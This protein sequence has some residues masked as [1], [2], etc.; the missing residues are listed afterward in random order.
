MRIVIDFSRTSGAIRSC[1]VARLALLLCAF[2]GFSLAAR[3]A[4]TTSGEQPT[5]AVRLHSSFAFADF[6][7]DRQPDLATAEVEH[8][9]S[10][11]TRY[12]IRLRMH[13]NGAGASQF[14]GVTGSFGL[15][16]I[17]ALD[18]NG[19]HVP[20][21]IVTA[22]GQDRPIAIL[23]NDGRGRFSIVSA[24]EFQYVLTDSPVH[25]HPAA[26]HL[27]DI[28]VLLLPRAPQ[29]DAANKR[30]PFAPPILAAGPVYASSEFLSD[31]PFSKPLG[32]APP[33]AI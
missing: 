26:N 3:A 20:D 32:R 9:D 13:A 4:K 23:L 18:V 8:A 33:P 28:A 19:D 11:L 30:Q 14:I 1:R 5:S 27:R 29:A 24:S 21:L 22:A 6:D 7:G 2:M 12:L 17:S 25:W 10:R 31:S 16:R 15:P